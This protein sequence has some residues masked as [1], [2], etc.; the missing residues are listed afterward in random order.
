MTTP[1][2]FV[3]VV[4]A[5]L[6][7]SAAASLAPCRA[8]ATEVA[9]GTDILWTRNALKAAELARWQ[10]VDQYAARIENPLAAKLV[11]WRKLIDAPDGTTFADLD[12]FLSENPRWPRNRRMLRHAER[13]MPFEMA[14]EATLAW[15][16]DRAP[17]SA[18][19]A[20]RIAAA[21]IAMGE[22]ERGHD[23][24]RRAWI[25]GN[26]TKSDEADIYKRFK[27]LLTADDHIKRID[28]LLWDGHTISAER[29]R[30]K[31]PEGWRRLAQA[32]SSLRRRT[33]NVD[34]LVS[35][36]PQN[37]SGDLGLLYERLRW[38]RR[39]NLD[40]TV[41]LLKGL[42]DNLPR[43]ELWWREKSV[44]AR[45]FLRNGHV[46]DAYTL[47]TKHGLEPGGED[48]AEAEWMA[49]WIALR[50]LK[51]HEV[52]LKHFVKLGDAVDYPLS[53][54]RAAYWA[55]RAAE[56]KGDDEAAVTW[57]RKAAEHPFAYYGQL[58]YAK[59][60]PGK[61]LALPAA[62]SDAAREA[63]AEAFKNHELVGVV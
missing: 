21:L 43:P 22:K 54:S 9:T 3:T 26:Y 30:Y 56:A 48:Y 20:I 17:A 6:A 61:G 5:A 15:F 10:T 23:M 44:L 18:E 33:G 12:A 2:R 32:R 63:E 16:G 39:K 50:F 36:V 52:A 29:M 34:Y 55:G 42:P 31:V 40:T 4:V 14:P 7:V 62:V 41:D 46:S 58:A 11:R 51:D 27:S 53:V 19:G 45:Q 35:K 8:S 24:V 13:L 28:R 38:H 59:L 1:G 47:A 25:N 37:L 57:Y 60:R 49:G